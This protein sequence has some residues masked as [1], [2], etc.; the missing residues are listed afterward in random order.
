M[1]ND[2]KIDWSKETDPRKYCFGH[3]LYRRL[4]S[5][6]TSYRLRIKDDQE[7]MDETDKTMSLLGDSM[8]TGKGGH[9]E[10]FEFSIDQGVLVT[11]TDGTSIKCTITAQLM[12]NADEGPMECYLTSEHGIVWQVPG[13]M[14]AV[15]EEQC[16]TVKDA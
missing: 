14:S 11:E 13:M 4:V 3:V 15:M 10:V 6:V 7:K 2:N 5:T 9:V 8:F 12:M 1:D 16:D